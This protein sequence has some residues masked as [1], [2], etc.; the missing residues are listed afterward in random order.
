MNTVAITKNQTTTENFR[1]LIEV[2]VLK[3]IKDLAEKGETPKEKVQAIAQLTLDLIKPDMDIDELYRNAV[4]LDDQYS[5][6]AP[7]VFRIMKEY[8][9]KYAQ[10]AI[11][12]VSQLIKNGQYDDAEKMVKKVLQFKM[13]N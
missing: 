4:K 11:G 2:E 10:K 7:I 9:D 13:I 5:E 8:E 12:P 1:K 3:I 6:L